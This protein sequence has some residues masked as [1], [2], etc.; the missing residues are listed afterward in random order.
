MK[1]LFATA[2]LAPTVKVGGL[3][4]FSAGLVTSL[5]NRDVEIDVVLPDYGDLPLY[6]VEEVALDLPD[7]VGPTK[8]RRGTLGGIGVS[9]VSV[10]NLLR[11]HPYLD[12]DG[13]GWPDNDLRFMSFSRAIAEW[14]NQSTPDVIHLNDWHTGATLG[15]IDERLPT[16]LTIHNLAYQGVCDGER[17][18]LLERR[19]SAFRRNGNTNLLAGAI[20]L[21]D[22]VV[23][24]SPT[25]AA[26]SLE[27]ETGFGL[28]DLMRARGK[29][30]TGILNGID[31]EVWDPAHDL[32]VATSYDIDSIDRKK[33]VKRDLI[34][35]LGWEPN[36]EP[37]VGIVTRLTEQKGVDIVLELVPSL[38]GLGARMVMLGSGE[39]ALAEA[40]RRANDHFGDRF[41]FREGYDEGL[42]HRIFGGSDLYLM[43]SRFEP[44]G[45][46]QMQAMRYGTIPVVTDVG[47]LHDTVFDSDSSPRQGTGFV[48]GEVTPASVMDAL[49]R[50]VAGWHSERRSKMI[51]RGMTRDWSWFRPAGLYLDLYRQIISARR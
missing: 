26:E 18:Q 24:V 5:R 47:G 31:T 32:H 35:E 43:P 12:A 33:L 40:A 51:K 38:Q 10:P 7:W 4:D 45:L 29:A 14:A 48:A 22:R 20:A 49:S 15:F 3:G 16:V 25:F 1:I 30:V 2:E 6:P 39:R 8:I 19:S 13:E 44:A 21:A 9:L 28:S 27:P 17:L 34:T 50:A 42:S 36:D 46:T 23:T 41:V 37:L 11:P